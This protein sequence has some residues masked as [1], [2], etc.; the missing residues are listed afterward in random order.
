MMKMLLD[1]KNL[2]RPLWVLFWTSLINRMGTMVIPFL[3][4]Y[5]TKYL[6]IPPEKAALIFWVY[7][8]TAFVLSP[9]LGWLSDQYGA[10]RIMILSLLCFSVVLIMFSFIESFYGA[11]IGS[12]FLAMTGEAFRPAA[13]SC[14]AEYAPPEQKKMAMAF[15]R[16]AINL[17][18]SVGPL[19]GGFIVMHSYSA[20]FWVDALTSL[21]AAV[22]LIV[23]LLPLV[24]KDRV[25]PIVKSGG[26][27]FALVLKDKV[28]VYFALAIIPVTMVFFQHESSLSIYMTH[29][30]GL[31]E[32]WYGFIFTVNT[33][34]I[35]LFEIP[36][37]MKTSH[38]SNR[39][40]LSIG[41][42]FFAVGFGATL[43][44][45]TIGALMVTVAI[46]TVGEMILF[47]AMTNYVS[48][49][50]PKGR[51]GLYMGFY[52]MSFSSAFIIGPWLGTTVLSKWGTTPLWTGCFV[53]GSISALM[54][55]RAK[56]REVKTPSAV[57][58]H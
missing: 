22:V 27:S 30:L 34:L 46:W 45:D 54:M 42:F 6:H 35:I 55:L 43:F 29:N 14:I 25:K 16:L 21:L 56:N 31:Q 17:G 47:P 53:F 32:S 23:F 9:S 28:F 15:H 36:L 24:P 52:A 49:L 8:L 19:L 26:G 50:A 2:P 48:E 4:I 7:G 18:M 40:T 20:L 33:I 38:W 44:A 3:L 51:Q 10:E 1:L 58:A 39:K 41:C 13:M 5:L 37:N 57:S 12:F 11:M